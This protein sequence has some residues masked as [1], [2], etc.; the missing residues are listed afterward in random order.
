MTSGTCGKNLT[1]TLDNDTLIIS[2]EGYMDNYAP[3]Y[4]YG[5]TSSPWY[6]SNSSIKRVI[7][8]DGVKSIGSNAFEEHH[9]LAEVKIPNS[10][11]VIE[12]NAFYACYSLKGMTIPYGVT[13]IGSN[14][15]SFCSLIWIT[16]PNSVTYIDTN[17]F[18]SCR[19]LQE[20]TIPESVT[21]VGERIFLN[22]ISLRRIYYRA[23]SGF[24]DKLAEDNNAKLIPVTFKNVK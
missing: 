21:G 11:T 14:A 5:G 3:H 6:Y 16:I 4:R 10:V 2:G 17:A 19:G 24:E 12:N 1:W 18:T 9:Y 15:F 23:G 22:C 20:V 13:T 8:E 7:I